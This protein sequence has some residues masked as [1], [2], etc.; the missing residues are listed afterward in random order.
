MPPPSLHCIN[1]DCPAP[2]PQPP[3]HK[4]C[5]RC[6]TSLYFQQRYV[7]MQRLG[8]GGFAAIFTVWDTR[9]DTEKVLKVL[10][11][12]AEK[13]L[14]LFVQEALV[15]RS[16]HH[17]G[18]PRVEPNSFF[19]LK[20]PDRS[21]YCLVM[22]KIV[23]PNLEDLLLDYYPRGCPELLVYEWLVQASAILDVLHR[24]QIVH[25]DIKPSNLMLRQT[26][27]GQPGSGQLVLID[28]GGAKQIDSAPSSTRLFSSGY[29]PPEQMSG[30]GVE[31]ATDIYA[32][33]RTAI[34]LLTSRHPSELEDIETGRLHW[35]HIVTLDAGLA[36]LLDAMV[37]PEPAARPTSARRLQQ[38]L[39]ALT[40]LRQRSR[41]QIQ[42]RRRQR[43]RDRLAPWRQRGQYWRSRIQQGLS[44]LGFA[45]LETL[46]STVL[47]ATS[48]AAGTLAGSL[49]IRFSAGGREFASAL[50]FVLRELSNLNGLTA[51]EA[52][53]PSAIAGFVL[54]G[55]WRK[56]A[57]FSLGIIRC[58]L[59]C[60][61]ASA[62]GWA[63]CC[64]KT[65]RRRRSTG[66]GRWRS[67][68]FRWRS[69]VLGYPATIGC[70]CWWR[71]WVWR[72]SSGAW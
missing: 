9:Q 19:E 25:R 43:W 65:W 42:A 1:P 18:V 20:T 5:Q 17:P 49:V 64:G 15:L 34:H 55:V 13:A 10:T 60:V 30:G 31:P 50:E 28:F 38:R 12:A 44:W 8:T 41:Q 57:A 32:L 11:V 58:S 40:P 27:P 51:G 14:Q 70:T 24:R 4:F 48:A 62:M 22:E 7:P 68:R 61:A 35:Q 29:S 3:H 39:L 66:W 2:Q 46:W 72:H 45:L 16:L 59:V 6:G 37:E 52:V 21:L 67:R 26:T 63:G 23:G 53:L 54:F 56:R 69:P 47:T 36:A 71:W 33:G